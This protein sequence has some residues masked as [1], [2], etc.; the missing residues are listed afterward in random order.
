MSLADIVFLPEDPAHDHEIEEINAEAF[1]PG[2]FAKAAYRIREGGPHE[3]AL[4]FVA[5]HEGKV[6]ASV[7]LTRIV[8]GEGRALLLGPL[9][10]RPVYKNNGIGKKLVRIAL[11]AA[12]E[13][14]AGVVV[15]VGD[16]PYYGPLGFRRVPNGQLAMP[17]PV[18]PGRLLAAELQD[19]ALSALHGMAMHEAVVGQSLPTLLSPPPPMETLLQRVG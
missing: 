11:E 19:G 7:R 18:D 17:R 15:L 6:V 16:E 2:R 8:A 1:G 4:S 13:A 5:L 14:G 9:A 12:R 10:V 3:R